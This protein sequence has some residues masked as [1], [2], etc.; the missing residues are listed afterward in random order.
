MIFKIY[1]SLHVLFAA[2]KNLSSNFL[3]VTCEKKFL[4]HANRTAVWLNFVL[5][6]IFIYGC[7]SLFSSVR[8]L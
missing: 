7:I 4:V 3:L 6:R 1:L 5:I 8:D 2:F